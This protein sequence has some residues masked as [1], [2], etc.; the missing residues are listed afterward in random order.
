MKTSSNDS[1]GSQQPTRPPTLLLSTYTEQ[2]LAN[3]ARFTSRLTNTERGFDELTLAQESS[4]T[5]LGQYLVALLRDRER[6]LGLDI[7]SPLDTGG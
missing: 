1:P 6:K 2:R 4:V 5:A 3:M 7:N